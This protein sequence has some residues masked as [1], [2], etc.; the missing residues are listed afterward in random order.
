M[1]LQK[2][3][4][5]TGADRGIGYSI[6]E[7]LGKNHYNVCINYLNDS[8]HAKKLFQILEEHGSRSKVY[9]AD[10]TDVQQIQRLFDFF[11]KEFGELHL[12]VNNAGITKFS[13]FL[14]TTEDM[15]NEIV[16]TDFKGAYFAAQIAAKNMIQYKTNG[17]IINISSNHTDGC[18]PNA[19]VY[20]PVKAALSKF[21][22]HAALEL[23]QYNIR[24][25]TIAPGYTDTGWEPT[26]TLDRIRRKLPLK[27]FAAPEEIG[28]L[29]LFLA[30][31][32]ASYMTGCTVTI[33]GGAILAVV[34][35]NESEDM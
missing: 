26:A 29:V 20:G 22:K 17:V 28:N 27:R 18:W 21:G 13:P 8:E 12:L 24:V 2:N 15:W 34:P 1:A 16:F 5:V 35:E 7:I 14:E 30:S 11:E 4:L 3:A 19:S 31:D 33:D 23:A 6:T 10:I 32:R 25:V 9:Q